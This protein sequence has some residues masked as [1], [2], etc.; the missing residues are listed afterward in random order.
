[1]M[2]PV[3][4]RDAMHCLMC[5]LRFECDVSPLTPWCLHLYSRMGSKWAPIRCC[6]ASAC[7]IPWIDK[8]NATHQLGWMKPQLKKHLLIKTAAQ[9]LRSRFNVH[10][11]TW[12]WHSIN[13]KSCNQGSDYGPKSLRRG[14]EDRSILWHVGA[15]SFKAQSVLRLLLC[16][17]STLEGKGRFGQGIG[18]DRAP[19]AINR[20]TIL[21]ALHGR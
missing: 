1:M 17:F 3:G 9:L 11:I 16:F 13:F 15:G 10:R 2:Y 19:S 12:P 18:E 6:A 8:I 14:V 4:F 21:T 5:C 20:S 7:L